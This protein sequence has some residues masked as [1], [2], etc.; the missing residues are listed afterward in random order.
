MRSIPLKSANPW[1]SSHLWKEILKNLTGTSV[2]CV[3]YSLVALHSSMIGGQWHFLKCNLWFSFLQR[4]FPALSRVGT[5][6]KRNRPC[7]QHCERG[8]CEQVEGTSSLC[9]PW[10]NFPAFHD[11]WCLRVWADQNGG[12]WISLCLIGILLGGHLGQKFIC[13]STPPFYLLCSTIYWKI[14]LHFFFL[15]FLGF[16]T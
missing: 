1:P 14:H 10:L 12:S 11:S 9:R 2:L 4:L 6:S 15:I 8:T 13:S 5:N 16:C 3:V 7:S